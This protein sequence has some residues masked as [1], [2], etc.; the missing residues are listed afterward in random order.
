M[1]PKHKV[2]LSF[3]SEDLAWKNKFEQLFHDTAEV[4]VSRSVQENDI[5]D[6]LKTETI[7]Q[8]IR[9]EYLRD[10]TVTIV[11]I[12]PK[13]W[14]R[15]HV[16]WEIG[17]SLRDTQYNKRSGLIGILLPNF[18]LKDNEY[19]PNVVP[20]RLID[21]IKNQFAAIYKWNESPQKIKEY[22]HEAF[23]RKDKIIP[24]NSRESFGK[25]RTTDNW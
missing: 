5:P 20:P 14:Q 13:T 17:S 3:H 12:G 22:I 2:F 8:K 18:P 10:S 24:D 21:N 25:N 19:Y 11:L 15:K 7:R 23:L 9:D 1:T 16:D 6:G 4:I